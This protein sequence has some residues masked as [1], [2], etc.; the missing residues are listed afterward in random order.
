MR[1]LFHNV[2][3]LLRE[4][5]LWTRIH[6]TGILT[7]FVIP[8]HSA[9]SESN[10]CSLGCW[11]YFCR[12]CTKLTLSVF[13][14]EFIRFRLTELLPPSIYEAS[15]PICIEISWQTT[16]LSAKTLSSAAYHSS[17]G[18]T[19]TSLHINVHEMPD[20]LQCMSS[21]FHVN[22]HP[23]CALRCMHISAKTLHIERH[24]VQ[25]DTCIYR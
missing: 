4:N 3:K 16:K 14:I 24:F 13:G 1:K 5:P 21:R 15:K 8:L 18:R 2:S 20:A 19:A 6:Y 7:T 12:A 22:S 9:Y 23:L 10:I 25:I 17:S 11:D